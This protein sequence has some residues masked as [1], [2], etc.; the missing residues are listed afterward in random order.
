MKIM[1][2]KGFGRGSLN[3]M[4]KA[5]FGGDGASQKLQVAFFVPFFLDDLE[6]LYSRYIEK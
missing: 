6:D 3:F 2:W 4:K 5:D 1:G